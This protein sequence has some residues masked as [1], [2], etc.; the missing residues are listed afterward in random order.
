VCGEMA[1]GGAFLNFVEQL[2]P[3]DLGI[4]IMSILVFDVNSA[5]VMALLNNLEQK[6]E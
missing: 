6:K 2:C 3:V 1:I 4:I 5:N